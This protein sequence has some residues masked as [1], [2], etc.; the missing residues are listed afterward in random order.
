MRLRGK[1]DA[2]HAEVVKAL[3]KVG[4]TVQS[5][6]NVGAGCPDLLVARGGRLVLMEVKDGSKEK[7]RQALTE[8]QET[9]IKGWA[10]PVYVVHSAAEAVSV[11]LESGGLKMNEVKP[12]GPT[13]GALALVTAHVPSSDL[14]PKRGQTYAGAV[15]ALA[16]AIDEHVREAVGKMVEREVRLGG[17]VAKKDDAL[18]AVWQM[19]EHYSRSDAPGQQALEEIARIAKEALND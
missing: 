8:A 11:L 5:L 9:W 17:I 18:G 16:L 2:N 10:S 12:E 13:Q 1:V 14:Y 3:R 4:A 15:E 7:A 19:A 6:A